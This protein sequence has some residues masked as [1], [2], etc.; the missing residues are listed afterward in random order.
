MYVCRTHT[1]FAPPPP[2]PPPPPQPPAPVPEEIQQWQGKRLE[3]DRQWA[4]LSSAIK[5]MAR[6]PVPINCSLD[7]EETLQSAVSQMEGESHE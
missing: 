7:P 6:D 2:P 5:G 4:Q 1:Y 3:F